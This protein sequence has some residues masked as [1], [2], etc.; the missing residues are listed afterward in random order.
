MFRIQQFGFRV[1]AFHIGFAFRLEAL[2]FSLRFRVMMAEDVINVP[3]KRH[4]AWMVQN[5][6]A[7]QH[8]AGHR[9]R[10]EYRPADAA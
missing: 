8:A 10:A 2:G 4:Y 3:D 6:G 1:F 5:A 9:F 7:V